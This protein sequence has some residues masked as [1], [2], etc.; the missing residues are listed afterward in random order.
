MPGALCVE[1]NPLT[2]G[3]TTDLE[4]LFAVRRRHGH[5]DAHLADLHH[6]ECVGNGDL[7]D[8]P[9]AQSGCAQFLQMYVCRVVD[10]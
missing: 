9:F 7:A 6:T 3:A 1:Q 5:D 10:H 8:V 2:T 4:G